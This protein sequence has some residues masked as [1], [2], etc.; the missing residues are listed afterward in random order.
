VYRAIGILLI[1]LLKIEKSSEKGPHVLFPRHLTFA[2]ESEQ[3]PGLKETSGCPTTQEL[4]E[5]HHL[6]ELLFSSKWNRGHQPTY[7]YQIKQSANRG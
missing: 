5:P 7:R 2:P 3:R 6:N 4:S 1:H